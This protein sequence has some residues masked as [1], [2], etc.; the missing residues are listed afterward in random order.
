MISII[1]PVWNLHETTHECLAAVERHTTD[2][3]IVLV[4]NGSTPPFDMHLSKGCG[5]LIRN[6][7]NRGFPVAINQGIREAAGNYLCLLNNDAIVTPQWSERMLVHLIGGM[8]IVGPMNGYGSGHQKTSLPI[9][10]DTGELDILAMEFSKKTPGRIE[11]VNWIIGFCMVFRKSLVERIG[12]FDESFHPCCGEEID[13]CLRARQQGFRIGVARD[14]YVHHEG[15]AT[16]KETHTVNE[17]NAL[18]AKTSNHLEKKWGRFAFQQAAGPVP[19]DV[20][21]KGT[22]LNLGCGYRKIEGAINIDNRAECS[23]DLLCDVTEGLPFSDNSIC[24]VKA[25]DFLEH[26]PIGKTVVVLEEIYRVLKPGGKLEHLTPSTEGRGAFMDP[27][28]VSFWNENSFKY[29]I[30]EEYRNLYGIKAK[31]KG[32]NKTIMTNPALKICHVHGVLYAD[33]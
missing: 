28:H 8:D 9:Y 29:F 7:E 24:E 13:F 19:A 17:Y 16:F 5:K 11:E 25:F 33:K 15:S 2:Y 18:C 20:R 3:E 1:I 14:V 26:I 6:E 30:D 21:E 23:P 31:F 32:E 27:N 4:D 10:N 22:I 12:Y